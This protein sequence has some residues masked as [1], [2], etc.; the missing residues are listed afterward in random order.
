MVCPPL[1]GQLGITPSKEAWLLSLTVCAREDLCVCV[2]LCALL[3]FNLLP[4]HQGLRVAREEH[5][6][7]SFTPADHSL[8]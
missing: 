4:K 8:C 5:V 3:L 1:L 2:C 6:E 7:N